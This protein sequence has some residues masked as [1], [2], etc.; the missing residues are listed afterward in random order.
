MALQQSRRARRSHRLV[1]RH[2]RRCRFS[3]GNVTALDARTG[4]VRWN[5][6]TGGGHHLLSGHQR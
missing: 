5:H 4:E 1:S 3:D 6:R 2:C